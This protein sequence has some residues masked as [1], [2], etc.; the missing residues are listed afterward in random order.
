AIIRAAEEKNA[1][2][3]IQIHPN[4]IN[5]VGDNFIAYVRQAVSRTHIPM[6][7]HVDHGATLGDCVRGIHNGYTSVMID[8]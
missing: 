7:I 3:I 2:A 6:A 4:E 1:P 8:A 5:L